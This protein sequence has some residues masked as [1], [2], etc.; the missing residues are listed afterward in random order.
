MVCICCCCHFKHIL[1]I[2]SCL[3]PIYEKPTS[4]EYIVILALYQHLLNPQEIYSVE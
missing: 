1:Y 4:D 3:I 2:T